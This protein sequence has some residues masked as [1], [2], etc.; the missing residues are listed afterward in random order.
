[1]GSRTVVKQ[2]HD[3]ALENT[4]TQAMPLAWVRENAAS[5]EALRRTQWQQWA[6]KAPSEARKTI[7]AEQ[8]AEEISATEQISATI[9]NTLAN[10]AARLIG[11]HAEQNTE[12]R[13]KQWDWIWIAI[14]DES[15]AEIEKWCEAERRIM[16]T[17][18]GNQPRKSKKFVF[19]P[20]ITKK[21]KD[22]LCK[23]FA[24]YEGES[25]YHETDY[26]CENYENAQAL[27]TTLNRKLGHSEKEVIRTVL[28]SMKF[29]SMKFGA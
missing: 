10:S 20:D 3:R 11:T 29:G 25:G 14:H 6:Q 5:C 18:G 19:T 7:N 2:E 12:Q 28:E 21:G 8:D 24:V 17:N 4:L 22:K 1:M 26:E 15:H 27:S 23:I 9:R 16:Q 13:Q